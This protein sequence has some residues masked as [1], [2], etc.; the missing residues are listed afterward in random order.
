M[1]RIVGILTV[2]LLASCGISSRYSLM[3]CYSV[4]INKSDNEFQ[5]LRIHPY[6][7]TF[8]L[9]VRIGLADDSIVGKYERRGHILKLYPRVIELKRDT[10]G[11]TS[12]MSH[13]LVLDG[14]QLDTM[15]Y[16]SVSTSTIKDSL[17]S[18][19]RIQVPPNEYVRFQVIG[20]ADAVVDKPSPGCWH[21]LMYPDYSQSSIQRWVIRNKSISSGGGLKFTECSK[22]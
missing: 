13:F 15:N 8:A 10:S 2:L 12:N 6:D 3:S 19:G 20:Y 9:R 18:D 4:E 17:C 7:S 21:V 14:M 16:V 5:R 22:K 11:C 1:K